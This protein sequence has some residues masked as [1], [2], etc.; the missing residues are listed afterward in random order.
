[1]TINALDNDRHI[2][3]LAVFFISATIVVN[4]GLFHLIPFLCLYMWFSLSQIFIIFTLHLRH[5]ETEAT[6]DLN[7]EVA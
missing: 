4:R 3:I 6:G 2:D 1:M 5:R 7:I